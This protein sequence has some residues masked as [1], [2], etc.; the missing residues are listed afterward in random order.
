V[1]RLLKS[2]D[3]ASLRDLLRTARPDEIPKSQWPRFV[4]VYEQMHKE[5]ADPF[6]RLRL[7]HGLQ[8]FGAPNILE[9]TK[10]ELDGLGAEQLK[11]GDN[12]GL[13]RRA[14]DE[15]QKSDPKW[16]SEWATRKVLNES[17]WFGA[18]PSLITQVSNEE[19]E[20]LFARFYSELLDERE[21]QRVQ[22]VLVSVMDP[23]LAARA[24]AR[25]CEIR[26]GLTFPPGHDQ[27][28][29]NLFRQVEDLLRAIAPAMLLAGISG[30][31]DREPEVIDLDVLT[32]VLPATNLTKADAR[33]SIS[34][35]MRFKLRAYLKRGARLGE[36]PNGLR[37]STRAHLAM[38]LGNVGKPEDLADIR[39]LI[40]ADSIR[41]QR[42]HEARAK[43]DRS[44]DNVG[45]GFLYFDAL[46]M[47]DP[48]A[49]DNVLVELVSTQQ[50]EHV[51]AQRLP[52]LARKRTRQPGLGTDR[53]DFKK[54]WTSRDGEPDESF[55]EGR[56]IRFADAILE[57]IER[58]KKERE[59]ATDKRGFHHRLKIWG[60]A[61][62]ALDGKRSAKLILELMELPGRWDGYTRVAALEQLLVSGVRLSLDD[63]LRILDA[64]I[65]ELRSSGLYNN[66]NLWLFA[67]CLAVMAFVDPP[68][69]GIARIR[70]MISDLRYRTYELSG[71]VAALGA[72]RCDDALELLMEIAG[73]DGKG[74]NAIGEGW[75]EAI[76]MIEGTR[77][78]EILLSFVDPNAK[79]FNRE[80]IP[81][82]RHGDLLA[83]LLAER[84][85]KDKALKG[86]LVELANGDLPPTKQMLLAKVFAQFAGEDDRVQGL[87]I[88]RDDGSGVPYELVRSMENAFLEH[89]PYGA[90]GNAYTVSPL[91]CDAVRKRL[92]EMVISDPHRKESAF[93]LLGQIEVWRL[94]HGHPADEPRHP[95]I[96]SEVSWPP[97]PS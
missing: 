32:D 16:V 67:R 94:E 42:A 20:G 52:G 61:L 37:G 25:A 86:K 13:I 23:A 76:G 89:R 56:R 91:G 44:Q 34:E 3:D 84:A 27:A 11:P 15:L 22:S 38:L 73:P 24:L 45:Y 95:V 58:I 60:G 31:L 6:E 72:S 8:A 55:V 35:E 4:A 70:E 78:S 59:E 71:V 29:W 87:C 93:A 40:E 54:I 51:L 19:R 88:L 75:I 66:Q 77:S 96:E 28:K 14:L 33:S 80:F 97:F 68:A 5:A 2:L 46:T 12:Q 57:E 64:A 62:A 43:G 39:R 10:V 1:E 21:K 85:V 41:F 83:R 18:W 81:D 26:A 63:A 49:A 7:L 65:Q 90:Y 82:H 74:V 17:I 36:H 92:F 79:L 48:V 53:I 9:R 69:A 30:R 50:Y 47:I